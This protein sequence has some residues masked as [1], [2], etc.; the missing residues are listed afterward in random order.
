MERRKFL[1]SS[2]LAGAA[3][4]FSAVKSW[5]RSAEARVEIF[6]ARPGALVSP[7]LFGQFAEHIGGVIYDGIWV[8]ED[9]KIS[10][11]FGIRSELIDS[12]SKIKV[13]VIRWPGGC[14]ADSYDW[15]EGIGP[16]SQRP[17]RTTM[18]NLASQVFELHSRL[19]AFTLY[20]VAKRTY[21]PGRGLYWRST[22]L[23]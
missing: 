11:R 4:T 10:N 18:C 23:P 14:F 2:A 1:K 13:P 7:N 5:A 6:G 3:L 19:M 17:T 22:E 15:T 9:S 8:G 12:L 20:W 21:A 16:T